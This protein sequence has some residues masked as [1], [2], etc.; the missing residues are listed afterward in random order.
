MHQ[1]ICIQL[2]NSHDVIQEIQSSVVTVENAASI[3]VSMSEPF[4]YKSNAL[5]DN[6]TFENSISIGLQSG[7]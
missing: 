5:S 4:I 3:T 6:L 7:L 2:Y 1:E